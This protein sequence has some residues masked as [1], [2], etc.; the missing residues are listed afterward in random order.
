MLILFMHVREI[1]V[2]TL[3]HRRPSIS[4][5]RKMEKAREIEEQD[6]KNRSNLRIQI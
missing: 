2:I 6:E 4:V 5:E 3:Q 1:F